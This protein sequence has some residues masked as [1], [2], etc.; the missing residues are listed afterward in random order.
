MYK[1]LFKPI[2]GIRVKERA[3]FPNPA[4]LGHFSYRKLTTNEQFYVKTQG[5]FFSPC[6]LLK[7]NEVAY[8]KNKVFRSDRFYPH[9]Y[10]T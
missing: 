2:T 4:N 5:K 6:L 3:I 9:G 7:N 8:L 1:N 10:K